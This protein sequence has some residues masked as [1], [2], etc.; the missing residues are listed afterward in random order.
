MGVLTY[1]DSMFEPPWHEWS[2]D[3]INAEKWDQFHNVCTH[4]DFLKTK[5]NYSQ[6]QIHLQLNEFRHPYGNECLPKEIARHVKEW[7]RPNEIFDT[8]ELVVQTKE[9]DLHS[10]LTVNEP[11]M[12]VKVIN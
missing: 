8:N 10:L 3:F 5:L 9:D 11:L 4:Y 12:N 6:N 2:N 7:K 1:D